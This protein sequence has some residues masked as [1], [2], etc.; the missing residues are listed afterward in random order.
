MPV[1]TQ[2]KAQEVRQF[3]TDVSRLDSRC[4][5]K[6]EVEAA[7]DALKREAELAGSG[8]NCRLCG[9]RFAEGDVVAKCQATVSGTKKFRCK[10]CNSISTMLHRNMKWP[11]EEFSAMSAYVS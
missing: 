4:S 11:P 2:R 9:Q 8:V 7:E 5:V 10:K 3:R 6:A 1:G